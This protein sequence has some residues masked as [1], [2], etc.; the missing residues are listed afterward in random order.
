MTPKAPGGSR[1]V[2]FRSHYWFEAFGMSAKGNEKG[3]VEQ[4]NGQ[5][6]QRW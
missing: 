1:S 3:G 4:E 6:R 2:A 5:F